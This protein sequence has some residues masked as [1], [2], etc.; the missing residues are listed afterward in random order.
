MHLKVFE[1]DID[2]VTGRSVGGG[3]M[4]RRIKVKTI[5]IILILIVINSRLLVTVKIFCPAASIL[6]DM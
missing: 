1:V 6:N 3:P 2:G 5:I 4:H